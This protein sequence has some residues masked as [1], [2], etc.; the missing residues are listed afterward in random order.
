MDPRIIMKAINRR[1]GRVLK[2]ARFGL[3]PHKFD[4]LR[5][6]IMDEFGHK[7]LTR[8]VYDLCGVKVTDDELKAFDRTGPEPTDSGKKGGAP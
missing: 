6:V 4:A 5:S 7:G 1:L 8:E 2:T 3:K